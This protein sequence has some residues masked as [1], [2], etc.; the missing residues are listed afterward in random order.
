[1]YP[2]ICSDP[3]ELIGWGLLRQ[4]CSSPSA[5]RGLPVPGGHG[6]KKGLGGRYLWIAC[7]VHIKYYLVVSPRD[8]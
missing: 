5:L 8:G 3:D 2:R 4:K 6:P 1:M 7:L